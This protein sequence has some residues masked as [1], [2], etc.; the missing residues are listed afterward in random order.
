MP[1]YFN[2]IKNID[3]YDE[4]VK[5]GQNETLF[6]QDEIHLNLQGTILLARCNS[7]TYLKTKNANNK[8]TI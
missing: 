2:N 4:F 7:E 1:S 3:K 5:V 6:Q 8:P